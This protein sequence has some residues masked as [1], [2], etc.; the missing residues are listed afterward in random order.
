[1]LCLGC[2]TNQPCTVPFEQRPAH[3]S[4]KRSNSRQC[5]AW[6]HRLCLPTCL[7]RHSVLYI[8][9]HNSVDIYCGVHETTARLCRSAHYLNCVRRSFFLNYSGNPNKTASACSNF[10]VNDGRLFCAVLLSICISL[11]SP[12]SEIINGAAPNLNSKSP[13]TIRL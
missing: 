5:R 1:M 6:M 11:E 12:V 2:S 3:D 9:L 10:D 8:R 13:A 4:R 7:C